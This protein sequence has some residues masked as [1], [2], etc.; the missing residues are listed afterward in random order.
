[1]GGRIAAGLLEAEEEEEGEEEEKEEEEEIHRLVLLGRLLISRPRLPDECLLLQGF[2][3]SKVRRP[4]SLPRCFLSPRVPSPP[5]LP[6]E[7]GWTK[8]ETIE[9]LVRKSGCKAAITPELKGRISLT[10][11][12]PP[13]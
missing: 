5:I 12:S 11:C 13:Q 3:P 10:R 4:P 9:S 1:M 8:A 2:D 6:H 7:T